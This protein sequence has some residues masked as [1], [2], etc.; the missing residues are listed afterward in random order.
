V[1]APFAVLDYVVVHELC[2]LHVPDHSPRF[3]TLLERQRPHWRD[4]RDWL[5]EHGPELFGVD[6]PD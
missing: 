1:L 2:H 3:W 4:Q 6:S 5:R